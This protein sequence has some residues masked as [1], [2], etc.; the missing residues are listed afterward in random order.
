[1]VSE[2]YSLLTV[3]CNYVILLI[4]EIEKQ[5]IALQFQFVL[6][7]WYVEYL[8]IIEFQFLHMVRCEWNV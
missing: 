2:T 5:G 7:G 8:N 6:L 1:M 4:H 3:N